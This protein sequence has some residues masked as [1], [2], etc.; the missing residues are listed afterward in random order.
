MGPKQMQ[1]QGAICQKI[2]FGEVFQA[3]EKI[4]YIYTLDTPHSP[5]LIHVL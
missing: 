1:E 5:G 2:R 4:I 3:P